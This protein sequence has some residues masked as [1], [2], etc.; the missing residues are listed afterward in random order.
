MKQTLLGNPLIRPWEHHAALVD[1]FQM[2]EFRIGSFYIC[3]GTKPAG[4]RV[5]GSTE[6]QL[7]VKGG[8]PA[9]RTHA[10]AVDQ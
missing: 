4:D 5:N 8:G 6:S 7:W 9:P 1:D 3:W 2:E 10:S